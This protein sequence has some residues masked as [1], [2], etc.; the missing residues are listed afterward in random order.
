MN[1]FQRKL[2][3]CVYQ[4]SK[5]TFHSPAYLDFCVVR[6]VA[7]GK[8]TFRIHFRREIQKEQQQQVML[9]TV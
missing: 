2:H 1:P 9:Q 5:S 4:E 6:H 8:Q 7:H 3:L